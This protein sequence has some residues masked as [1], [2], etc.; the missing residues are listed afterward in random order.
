LKGCL[1]AKLQR[2]STASRQLHTTGTI[3]NLFTTDVQRVA[4]TSVVWH[5]FWV[6]PLQIAL[7]MVL[8]FSVV[9][10]AMFAGLGAIILVMA[11]NN[12]V[13]KRLR[14]SSDK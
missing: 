6:L 1:Y 4:D 8:L 3:V 11:G 7:S 2:L 14:A 13:S 12:F 10:Y 9:S 5:Y